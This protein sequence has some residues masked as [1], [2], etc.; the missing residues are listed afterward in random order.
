MHG[1]AKTR[2]V[3]H[4]VAGVLIDGSRV[5]ITRRRGDVHQ[6][7]KWEFP[8]GKL[9]PHE[10]PLAGLQ[11]ELWEELG[12]RVIDASPLM[13]VE[14][15]Y[16]EL[17]VRLEVYS[18]RRYEGTPQGREA[19]ELRWEDI[20]RL[21][22]DDFPDADHAILRRLQLSRLY[23]ISHVTRFGEEE[24]AARLR[25]ALAAGAR[26]VQLREPQMDR[27][28]FCAYARRLSAL[29]RPFHA[30][31]M[32]NVDPAWFPACEASGLHLTSRRL[33][34]LSG[35]PVG[36]EYWLGASCHDKAELQQAASLRVDFAV[37][38]PVQP[39]ES[40]PGSPVLG[41][42]GF[43]E[44]SR[45][46]GVP[47][48]AIGGMREADLARAQAAGAHGLAMIRGVWGEDKFADVV[49]HLASAN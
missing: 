31:L 30:R 43:A 8:G 17:D 23:L 32:V 45:S 36:A 38:G 40:H 5:C 20:F 21:K 19:Q 13:C 47:L 11:R 14:H 26:M 28:A 41:W 7:G 25:R 44:L 18:V 16:P 39:T 1:A 27:G 35:R 48:Y 4:V 37:L 9:E 15:A 10:E 46:A 34:A 29:C 2:R 12:I 24:F 33:M 3:I 22:A 42:D 49:R 6:G